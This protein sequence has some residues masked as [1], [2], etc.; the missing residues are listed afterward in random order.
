[1]KKLLVI[2]VVLALSMFGVSAAFAYDVKVDEDTYAKLG[3]KLQVRVTSTMPDP[4]DN[5][6]D[7]SIKQARFYASGQ[8]TNLVKFGINYDFARSIAAASAGVTDGFVTLDFSKEAKLMTGIYRVAFS[9]IGL[10]D[11]YQYIL[12]DGPEIMN[13]VAPVE[14]SANLSDYRNAGITLWGDLMDGKLRYNVGIWDDDGSAAAGATFDD[15]YLMTGRVVF[16]LGD[17]EKGYTCAGCYLGKANIMNVGFG[18]MMQDYT[19]VA[20][21]AD[22]TGT[23]MTFDF[24]MDQDGLTLEAAYVMSDDDLGA[25]GSEPT[26]FYAEAA[27]VFGSL[28]PAVRYESYDDDGGTGDYETIT[29]G[30]NW[31]ISGH[32]A[33]IQLAY[34]TKDFD[35]AAGVDADSLTAQL[36]VQF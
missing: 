22:H 6:N 34:S 32:D 9:R 15:K 4:G 10:Q 21:G 14:A 17:P 23:A 13:S 24:F 7:V 16:N 27:M 31:L 18:Y 19:V 12:I 5:E 29:A 35:N 20:T 25:A 8:V 2:L 3:P 1:M 28:Q 36:Q 26:G 30:V 33:K 11:S